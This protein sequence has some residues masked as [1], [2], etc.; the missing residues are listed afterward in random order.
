MQNAVDHAF[1]RDSSE[2]VAGNVLVRLGRDDGELMVEVIDD[3]V[4]L[5]DGFSVDASKG[6]GL[7]IVQA[8]VSGELGGSME[9]GPPERDGS[10]TH[11]RLRV[12]VAPSAPVEL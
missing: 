10:G 5:P 3:G 6:L 8:L 11:V 2:P 7:S 4:G 1:P 12:P 9:L